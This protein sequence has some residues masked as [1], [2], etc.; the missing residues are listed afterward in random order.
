MIFRFHFWVGSLCRSSI[1]PE[2]KRRYGTKREHAATLDEGAWPLR[3]VVGWGE[4]VRSPVFT[5]LHGLSRLSNSTAAIF[6][7]W[8]LD[9]KSLQYLS[10]RHNGLRIADIVHFG[11]HLPLVSGKATCFL[12]TRNRK[13]EIHWSFQDFHCKE[14]VFTPR[15][16]W[17]H[18]LMTFSRK[19]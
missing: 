16:N 15:A 18:L 9:W 17:Y 6:W 3:G 11:Y 4:V 10:N 14:K 13:E 1:V 5:S 7:L 12:M 19:D 2:A 8:V